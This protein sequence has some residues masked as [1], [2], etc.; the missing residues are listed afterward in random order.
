MARLK[1]PALVSNVFPDPRSAGPDGLV[2]IGGDLKVATL[3]EAYRLGIFPWPQEGLPLLWF[4][5]IERGIID[6]SSETVIPTRF[7]K[8]LK[9][10]LGDRRL[11][12]RLNT[13]FEDVI[14]YCRE[15]VRNGQDG[16][17]ILDEVETAYCELHR[18]GHA[19]SI[20]TY[21]DGKLAGGLYGVF[22]NGVFSGESMFHHETDAGKVAVVV[23]LDELRRAG[24]EFIDVQMVTPVVAMFGGH[25]ISREEYL[26]RLEMAQKQWDRKVCQYE[27]VRGAVS[28]SHIASKLNVGTF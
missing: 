15:A 12:V 19:H 2:A 28:L 16:T 1:A 6:L 3:L 13:A 24:L 21:L 27:W 4:S 8:K 9:K 10:W 20:E 25:L 22:V 26:M 7:A 23:I 17:W 11:E 14:S 18:Q 5:P